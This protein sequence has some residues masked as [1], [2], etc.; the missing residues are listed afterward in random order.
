ML[1]VTQKVAWSLFLGVNVSLL[2]DGENDDRIDTAG[3]WLWSEDRDL[4][5]GV[6]LSVW[7]Y[8]PSSHVLAVTQKIG[9]SLFL[10]VNV[11]YLM[12]ERL[13]RGK[14]Q[15]ESDSEVETAILPLTSVSPCGE[16]TLVPDVL[17]VTQKIDCPLFLGVNVSLLD[18][19]ENDERKD[20]V[21]I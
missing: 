21:G 2:D 16:V 17:A 12:L 10:G 9:W 7:R 5:S 20:T 11:S 19:G 6:Q 15:W 13:T 14:I 8:F 18:A 4:T 3:I 1:A